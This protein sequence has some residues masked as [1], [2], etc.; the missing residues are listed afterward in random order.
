MFPE[1]ADM[2]YHAIREKARDALCKASRRI[3][4]CVLVAKCNRREVHKGGRRSI[5]PRVQSTDTPLDK[6]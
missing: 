4:G 3:D 6:N 1:G 5:K 2:F